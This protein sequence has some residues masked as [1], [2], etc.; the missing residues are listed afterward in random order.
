MDFFFFDLFK[1]FSQARRSTQFNS[2]LIECLWAAEN[3]PTN[4]E[5]E[6]KLILQVGFFSSK[7]VSEN[8]IEKSELKFMKQNNENLILNH[9]LFLILEKEEKKNL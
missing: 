2:I 9:C 5:R 4:T 1:T 7:F 8:C 6:F 3:V